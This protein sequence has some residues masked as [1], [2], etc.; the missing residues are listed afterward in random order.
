[1][2]GKGGARD[3]SGRKRE[4]ECGIADATIRIPKKLKAQVI[5]YARE[6]DR[7]CSEEKPREQPQ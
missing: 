4:W 6:L 2:A 1:M 3:N 7:Q 5:K